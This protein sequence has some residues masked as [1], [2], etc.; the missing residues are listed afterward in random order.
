MFVQVTPDELKDEEEYEDIL[1]D[2]KEECNKYGVVRS[3]EIPRPID[4]VEVPGCGKV[5]KKFYHKNSC[6][7]FLLSCLLQWCDVNPFDIYFEIHCFFRFSLS[8]TLFLTV[9]RLNRP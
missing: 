7:Q 6:Y 9:K 1:E 2:I 4:G 5:N 8:S 3:I